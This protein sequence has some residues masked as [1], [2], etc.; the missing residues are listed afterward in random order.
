MISIIIPVFNEAAQI[1]AR[2]QA[3]QTLREWGCELL[4]VDGGSSDNSVELAEPWADKV[5]LAGL[6]RATQMNM[7]AQHASQK[8]L[9]FL[10]L[11]TQLPADLS[12]QRDVL[13]AAQWGFF[14]V[15]FDSRSPAMAVIASLMNLRSRLSWVAT[16]DQAIF[17]NAKLFSRLGGYANIPLMEDVE[18]CKRL[19]KLLR[20]TLLSLTVQ[21]SARRWQQRGLVKTVVSMWYLRLLYFWGASPK[22]LAAIYYPN[23]KFPE[24]K[25]SN[26]KY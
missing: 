12:S 8:L 5:L 20:P 6:G 23:L 17:I 3:L 21:T 7:G 15:C 24:A 19:R 14:S 26:D 18:I 13:L 9:L 11:D 4:V 2:L 10:H 16:G 25:A 22:S 1:T